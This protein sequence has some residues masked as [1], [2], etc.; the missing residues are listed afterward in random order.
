MAG[1]ATLTFNILDATKRLRDAGFDERQAET[2]MRVLLESQE[3]LV[4][5]DDLAALEQRLNAKIDTLEAR[6]E[7]K[8]T[9]LQWM[10]GIVIGGVV[11]LVLKAYFPV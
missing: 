9:L 3:R 4:T 8:I 1:M 6:M 7:G 2:V 11:M 10:L 5:K